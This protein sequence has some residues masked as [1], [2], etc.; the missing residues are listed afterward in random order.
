MVAVAAACT[1]GAASAD[2]GGVSFW[3]PG[4]FGSFAAVPTTPGWSLGAV[5]YH[6]SSDAGGGK[7]FPRGG[8]V[9]AGLDVT[10]DLLFLAPS[11]AFDDRVLGGQAALETERFQSG[12]VNH[13]FT[14]KARNA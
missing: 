12:D 7:E 10:A 6:A 1:I 4:Q 13:L 2:E 11:Y 14:E 3:L 5:Y 9:T 8:R